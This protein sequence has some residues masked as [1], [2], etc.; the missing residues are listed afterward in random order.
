MYEAHFTQYIQEEQIT[1]HSTKH[2][3]MYL[4]AHFLHVQLFLLI[5]VLG[6]CSSSST[7]VPS[8]T[9]KKVD[10]E[11]YEQQHDTAAMV[12]SR[13]DDPADN[14]FM[15][16]QSRKKGCKRVKCNKACPVIAD[17]EVTKCKKRKKKNEKVLQQ[18][19]QF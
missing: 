13:Q 18:M 6:C 7:E 5:A 2:K 1:P 15:I 9:T 4:F 3:L 14:I 8:S 19:P 12:Q 16:D 11:Q 17:G 10:L